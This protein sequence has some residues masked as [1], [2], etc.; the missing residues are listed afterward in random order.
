MIKK[1]LSYLK[2]VEKIGNAIAQYLYIED[3][4]KAKVFEYYKKSVDYFK[5]ENVILK[6]LK[7]KLMKKKHSKYIKKQ[8]K[9]DMKLHKITLG[10]YL[11]MKG[12][13]PEKDSK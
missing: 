12:E 10:V 13:V 1:H 5:L 3:N 8:L 2:K 7:Q 9:K 11:Y 6:K 4:N